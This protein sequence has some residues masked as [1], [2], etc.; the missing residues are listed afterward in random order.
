[1]VRSQPPAGGSGK[2][3]ESERGGHPETTLPRHA[4]PFLPPV[5][6]CWLK[7]SGSFADRILDCGAVSLVDTILPVVM[8]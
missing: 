2:E 8:V 3:G 6:G 7:R 1:M 4:T 5:P